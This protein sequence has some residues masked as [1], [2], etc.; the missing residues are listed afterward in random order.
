[1]SAPDD[2]PRRQHVAA[3]GL[4]LLAGLAVAWASHTAEPAEAYLFPRLISLAWV[5]LAA[6]TFGK[7][8][9]GRTRVGAG[10]HLPTMGRLAGGLAVMLVH[11]FWAAETL[12]FYTGGTLA[13][14][15]I[16]S[17]YDPAPHGA[18][19]SW[20]RRLAVSLGFMAVMYLLFSQLLGVFTPRGLFF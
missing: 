14:L 13:M 7:A 19:R 6:W 5:G 4:I 20:L 12:G 17:L 2:I 16:V 8:V 1:M 9:M 15:A 11:V 3:S 10:L 18:L